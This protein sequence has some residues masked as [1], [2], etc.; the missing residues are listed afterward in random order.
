M[1][2][3][4]TQYYYKLPYSKL[5]V[6]FVFDWKRFLSTVCLRFLTDRGNATSNK[7]KR[8]IVNVNN[9]FIDTEGGGNDSGCLFTN[10]RTTNTNLQK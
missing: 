7:K 6:I 1:T 2:E 4:C 9:N 8:V 5:L 10:S 3:F